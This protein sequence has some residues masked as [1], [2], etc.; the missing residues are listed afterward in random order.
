MPGILAIDDQANVRAVVAF[1]P[2][3]RLRDSWCRKWHGRPDGVATAIARIPDF[4]TAGQVA[5]RCQFW[6]LTRESLKFWLT[7]PGRRVRIKTKKAP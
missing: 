1:A 5:H 4:L 7:L 3:Q 2:R 6:Y